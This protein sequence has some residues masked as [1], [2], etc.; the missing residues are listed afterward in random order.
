MHRSIGYVLCACPRA[1]ARRAGGGHGVHQGVSSRRLTD[2]DR[3][4]LGQMAMS[5]ANDFAHVFVVVIG[6]IGGLGFQ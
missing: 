1:A 3:A 5:V 2:V 6:Q 4:A